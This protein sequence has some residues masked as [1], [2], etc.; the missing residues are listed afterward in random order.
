MKVK[1]ENLTGIALDW[2]VAQ[3]EGVEGYAARLPHNEGYYN[4]STNWGQGGTIIEREKIDT[5]AGNPLYFPSGNE[6][7]ES[8]EPLWLATMAKT[9]TR[10]FHGTTPLTAAMRCYVSSKLGEE[11]EIPEEIARAKELIGSV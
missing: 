4:Y 8:Y 11:V 10:R 7:G 1:T 6:K 9:G 2:A 5:L 3:C